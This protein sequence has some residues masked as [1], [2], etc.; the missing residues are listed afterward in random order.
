MR[1]S[2]LIILLIFAA[3]VF[4]QD[5]STV[6]EI[7]PIYSG[8]EGYDNN[9][10]R[11]ACMS[12]NMQ[13]FVAAHFNTELYFTENLEAGDY[14][15]SVVFVVDKEGNIDRV[16]AKGPTQNLENEAKRVVKSVPQM[17]PG[18][19]K[20]IPVRVLYNLPIKFRV[21]KKDVRKRKRKN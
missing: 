6:I 12:T 4:A 18:M 16:D 19:Q 17:K 21:T 15:I 11:K 5:S 13:R 10:D 7:P 14:K 9:K 20:G 8:C 2:L 1:L 3:P